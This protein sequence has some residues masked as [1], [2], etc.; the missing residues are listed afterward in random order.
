MRRQG[1]YGDSNV[2]SYVASQMQHMSSQRTHHG[3]G[4]NHFARRPDTLPSEEENPYISSKAE[5]QWQRDRDG[6]K[7]SNPLSSQ[8]Y[9]EGKCFFPH[10]SN[11]IDQF[12]FSHAGS[13]MGLDKHGNKDPRA[14]PH[15]QD[16]EVGYEDNASQQS[17]ESL[18]QKFHDE[19][20][21]L[22]KEQHEAE[23][24]ENA[25][26]RQKLGEINVQYQEKLTALRAQ[27]ANRR[28]DF[29]QR[30]SHTRKNQYQQAGMTHYQNAT[31]PS[32]PHGY[33]G[34]S[35]EE[36]AAGALAAYEAV[37]ARIKL[38]SY[39][40]RQY[41]DGTRKDGFESKGPYPGGRAYNTN[42][43]YY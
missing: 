24:V 27:H 12:V 7:G 6:T 10:L 36:A 35:A 37:E 23:D 28:D 31:G 42:P 39:L 14:Q 2:N 38:D 3:T 41:L 11:N 26:H 43:R 29:L 30:E 32:D 13:K 25:R 1:Q 18:T 40:E 20:I 16:M 33:G 4:M 22:T 21:K 9:N 17:F 15:E 19:I 5:A 8:I 34:E